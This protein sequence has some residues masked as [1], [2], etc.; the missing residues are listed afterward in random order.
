M[1]SA[2]SRDAADAAAEYCTVKSYRSW[3]F[4]HARLP[5]F[6]WGALSRT[7]LEVS[8]AAE[9]SSGCQCYSPLSR[10]AHCTP[11]YLPTY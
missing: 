7:Q 1:L 3:R 10:R 5:F 9:K 6:V 4:V 11:T 2:R 8:F